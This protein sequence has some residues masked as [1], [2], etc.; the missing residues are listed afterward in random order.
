[1]GS[2]FGG[3]EISKRSLFA[4]QTAL[5][6]TGHNI[7]NANTRGYTRQV[8]N[9]VASRPMEAPGM[10]SSNTPGQLGQG[11]EFDHI[12]RI[13]EKFLDS[14]FYNESKNNGEW[15]IRQDTLDKL[16]TVVNEPSDTGIRKVLESFWSSWSELSK[17]PDNLT[18]RA[19][20]KENALALTDAFNHV[21]TQ[22]SDLS[23]DLTSNINVK[24]SEVSTTLDQLASL[25][26]EIFRVEGLGNNANDLR[27]QRDVLVDDLSK[28][29]NIS[30]TETSS[31]YIV[32][33][34]NQELV[35]GKTVTAVVNPEFFAAAKASGDLN[36]GEV[37]GMIV[38]RDQIVTSFQTQLDNMVKSI[39]EG[40]VKVTLPSGTMVPSGSLDAAGNAIP[41]PTTADTQITVKGLNGLHQLGYTLNGGLEAGE[42]FFTIKA[43]ATALDASSITVNTN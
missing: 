35:N 12:N 23:S 21:S 34:G 36:N 27:D 42:P 41:R 37:N 3:I 5:Q 30:V 32:K 39:A 17:D 14:Q 43:G 8:V 2:T 9:F 15:S 24:A 4:Q 18:A 20:V 40:E 16:E 13:R 7:S 6:T 25:N 22:L 11:V 38:S 29:V 1:M 19:V 10:M 31:G 33:M 26:T 28:I